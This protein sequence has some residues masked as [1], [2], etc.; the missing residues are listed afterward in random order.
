VQDKGVLSKVLAI[1]GTVLVLFPFLFMI[2]TSLFTAITRHVLRIDYLMPGELFFIALPG[3]LLL[4]WAALRTRF[5]RALIGVG[6]L[7][8]VVFLVGSMAFAAISGLASG[9]VEPTGWIF[10]VTIALFAVYSLS[11]VVVGIAGVMLIKRLFMV[12]R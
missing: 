2:F 6:V 5:L 7:A 9:A 1:S 11:L 3:A 4:L 8:A 10:I 12:V